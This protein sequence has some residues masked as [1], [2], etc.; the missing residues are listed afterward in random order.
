[1]LYRLCVYIKNMLVFTIILIYHTIIKFYTRIQ[2]AF[3][4]Y[5]EHYNEQI[6]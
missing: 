3:D 1:M 4:I 2:I 5:N 6:F